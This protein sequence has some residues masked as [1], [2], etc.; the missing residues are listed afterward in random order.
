MEAL[1]NRINAASNITGIPE[2]LPEGSFG[3]SEAGAREAL[4]NRIENQTGIPANLPE[5]SFGI[6]PKKKFNVPEI[7]K[8]IT[9]NVFDGSGNETTIQWKEQF[10][11]GVTSTIIKESKSVEN[12]V[13][14]ERTTVNTKTSGQLNEIRNGKTY[15]FGVEV[16]AD[17]YNKLFE[18][19]DLRERT[20][21][22][23]EIIS[24]Y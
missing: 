4:T 10:P 3:I 13:I 2:D 23:K 21:L 19:Q 5:G 14:I 20:N 7:K 22:A 16:S 6:T 18:V 1:N 12:G 17:D 24:R 9:E 11:D 15:I 8:E